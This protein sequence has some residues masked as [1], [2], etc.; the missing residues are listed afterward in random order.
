MFRHYAN[1]LQSKSLFSCLRETVEHPTF[2]HAVKE[3]HPG[4]KKIH[5]QALRDVLLREPKTGAIKNPKRRQLILGC[6]GISTLPRW[7]NLCIRTRTFKG[8][9][10]GASRLGQMEATLQ[11]APWWE[12]LWICTWTFQRA[13][14]QWLAT[15]RQCPLLPQ[16][17][18]MIRLSLPGGTCIFLL[19]HF[20][21]HQGNDNGHKLRKLLLLPGE[22][23]S[24]K[25]KFLMGHFQGHHSNKHTSFFFRCSFA[26]AASDDT[27]SA[28][29]VSLLMYA[30]RSFVHTRRAMVVLPDAGGPC[31]IIA[32]TRKM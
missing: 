26:V 28:S 32:G 14:R 22:E 8:Q 7:G 1:L 15:L 3:L 16:W 19:E 29:S 4:W 2:P 27:S 13:P 18:S 6:K 20:Y 12:N 17:R 5:P 25:C 24:G 21:R 11:M 23:A 30:V 10:P 9:F 31:M